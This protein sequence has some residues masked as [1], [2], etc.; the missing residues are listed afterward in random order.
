VEEGYIAVLT[1]FGAAKYVPSGGLLKFRAGLQLKKPWEKV[2]M[3]CMKEQ[4]LD[5]SGEVGGR[6]AM[7]AD[8]TILR[9][10]SILRFVPVEDELDNFLFGLRAPFEHIVGLFTC[11]LRNEIANFHSAETAREGIAGV[12]SDADRAGKRNFELARVFGAEV[13]SYAVIRRERHALN[14]RIEAFCQ[15]QI[16]GRYGVRFAA[17]DLTDILPPDELADALNA[18]MQAQ[19][20]AAILYARAEGESQQR[21]LSAS[22]GVEIAK[23]RASAEEIEIE[24]VAGY[25]S[26]LA[27]DRTLPAYV[28]RRRAE[29]LA[30]A[31]THYV[32]RAET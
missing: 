31:R 3:V 28:A 13:S 5:L 17:V 30:E 11:L 2:H 7:T 6:S 21:V 8:G 18:V 15:A 22:R 12:E 27:R 24:G 32:K 9:F 23:A 20:E 4:N 10:D 26:E 25:L 16:G 29:V 1:S 14:Q 19:V